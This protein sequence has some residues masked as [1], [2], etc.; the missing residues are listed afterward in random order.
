M[1]VE[2]ANAGAGRL[3][4]WLVYALML[5]A[6]AGAFWLISGYGLTLTAPDRAG[7]DGAAEPSAP[8]VDVFRLL[9]ALAAVVVAGEALGRVFKYIGQPPVIGEVVGGILLGPTLLGAYSQN[10]LPDAAAP[11][12]ETV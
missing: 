9:L 4:A 2:R 8:P 12:L 1:S 6:A 5:V 11:S 3:T 7:R 10:V